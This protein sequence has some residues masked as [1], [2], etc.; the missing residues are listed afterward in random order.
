MNE[1]LSACEREPIGKAVVRNRVGSV[2]IQAG[3]YGTS[4]RV[5]SVY[6]AIFFLIRPYIRANYALA[7]WHFGKAVKQPDCPPL[8][9]RRFHIN[10]N[11]RWVKLI[12]LSRRG[13]NLIKAS[14]RATFAGWLA[15]LTARP[16]Q[17]RATL[18]YD[19]YR[20]MAWS[21]RS[22]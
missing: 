10:S 7:S 19:R 21:L 15:Y 16:Y 2:I 13:L 22:T 6:G 14:I 4:R 3:I 9:R 18:S 12:P 20:I 17:C 8:P 5:Y 1:Y 11:V